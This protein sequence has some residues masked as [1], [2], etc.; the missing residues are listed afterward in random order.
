MAGGERAGLTWVSS[1]QMIRALAKTPRPY[2]TVM[3]TEIFG[4][5]IINSDTDFRQFVDY[6]NLTG[7]DMALVQDSYKSVTLAVPPCEVQIS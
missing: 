6:A 7:L 5:G 2:G 3:A 4:L 1:L